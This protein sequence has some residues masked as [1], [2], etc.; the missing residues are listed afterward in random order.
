MAELATIAR[1]YAEAA[2]KLARE[3][4]ALAAWS[5]AL[6]LL[7]VVVQDPR[8]RACISDPNVSAPALE[9]LVLGV[10]GDRLDGAARNFVQVLIANGR[11]ELLVQIRAQYEALRRE[12]EGVLEARIVSALPLADEQVNDLV[13]RL[14]ARHQRKVRAQVDLDPQLIGGVMVIVGDKVIDGTVRGRLEAMAAAL[15]H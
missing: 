6:A 2:F 7:E 14:E 1:P 9:S 12:H 11:F 10:A 4:S 3:K 8:L 13:A 15:A 5:D